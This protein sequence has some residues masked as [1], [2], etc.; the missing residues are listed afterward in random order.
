[1]FKDNDDTGKKRTRGT[2]SKTAFRNID[3]VD[4]D[5]AMKM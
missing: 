2:R 5:F 1:M 4:E 3:E